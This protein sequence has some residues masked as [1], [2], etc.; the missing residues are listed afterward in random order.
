MDFLAVD[1]A[2]T[3][4]AD[5]VGGG[6]AFDQWQ[7]GVYARL[8]QTP[9]V[10]YVEQ[11]RVAIVE[12]T[13]SHRIVAYADHG[14]LD[15]LIALFQADEAV[16]AISVPR[17]PA[18]PGFREVERWEHF[19]NLAHAP[20]AW[21]EVPDGY[22]IVTWQTDRAPEAVE[23]LVATFGATLDGLYLTWPDFPTAESCHRLL[24]DLQAGAHGAFAPEA[25]F[26][27]SHRGKL[28]GLTLCTRPSADLCL[29]FE[30]AIRFRHRGTRLAVHLLDG[31]K[32]AMRDRGCQEVRF[33]ARGRNAAVLALFRPEDVRSVHQDTG[34]VWLR[35]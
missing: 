3:R 15:P 34:W 27:A 28:A 32:V 12:G 18:V 20:A 17:D 21:G 31:V 10:A 1:A 26:M 9:P 2:L 7:A 16:R 19:F 4:C 22:D 30:I 24:A 5:L 6:P 14:T 23:L 29:L 8:G 11:D 13:A 33:I 35:D 25:S